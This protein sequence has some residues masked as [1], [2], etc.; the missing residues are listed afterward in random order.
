MKA[1]PDDR[2]HIDPRAMT[3]LYVLALS[4]VAALTLAGQ[5]VVQLSLSALQD[6]AT[7]VNDAGR[8]RMLSQRIPRLT[9]DLAARDG[10]ANEAN[11]GAAVISPSASADSLRAELR[12]LLGL[13][14]ENHESLSRSDSASAAQP[15]NSRSVAGL[16]AEIDPHVVKVTQLVEVALARDLAGARPLLSSQ[17]RAELIEHSDAFLLGMDDAVSQLTSESQLRVARLRWIERALLL[18]TLMVL[19]CEGCFIFSPAVASLSRAF[20]RLQS[21]AEQL[22]VAKNAAESANRAKT[23]FLARVSHEL[24]TPL[25]AVLGMLG[26]VRSGRLAPSQR[27]RIELAT[28]GAQSLRRLVDDLLDIAGAESGNPL[29]L[30]LTAVDVAH[31]IDDCIGMLKPLAH[32]KRLSM[33]ATVKLPATHYMLD[34]FRLRQILMN[35][36][37]NAIRYT[38][39]GSVGCLCDL[40]EQGGQAWLRIAVRD[41]GRGIAAEHH[42]RIFEN[43][44]LLDSTQ[45]FARG[46]R[47][48][49][50]GLVLGLPITASLVKS[51]SGRL[52]LDSQPG[53]GSEFTVALPAV[54]AVEAS[55]AAGAQQ[56]KEWRHGTARLRSRRGGQAAASKM[57][58]LVVDDVKI[59]RILMREYLAQLQVPAIAVSD[60][61]QAWELVRQ[62]QPHWIFLDAHLPQEDPLEFIRRLRLETKIYQPIVF[63]VT[64]DIHFSINTRAADLTVDGVL[65]KPL[66]IEQ[67]HAA[68]RGSSSKSLEELGPLH[69][70]VSEESFTALRYQLKDLLRSRLPTELAALQ[71]AIAAGDAGSIALIGHRLRGSAANAGWTELAIACERIEITANDPIKCSDALNDLNTLAAEQVE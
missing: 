63:I 67:L 32:R 45:T 47:R 58:A 17:Q 1:K 28:S 5:F 56:A 42:E 25:H 13:W 70:P 38:D 64:A 50:N 52:T 69:D 44:V 8:Q 48:L 24:R 2:P 71:Q 3:R 23:D 21:L 15:L 34:E 6:D 54:T 40:A 62:H 61:T 66:S 60:L 57:Q 36:L 55:C 41:T 31:L 30:Q 26:L 27:R 68:L 37:Q 51:M 43:F 39:A 19:V 22:E 29:Q 12:A 9:L 49:G 20:Q 65:H 53:R 4:L 35:L 10:S 16:F 14:K 33:S 7:R 18:A 59:N 11:S 46:N